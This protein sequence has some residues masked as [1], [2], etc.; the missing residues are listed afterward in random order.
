MQPD[1]SEPH[2]IQNRPQQPLS[3]ADRSCLWGLLG[4]FGCLVVLI[5]LL[6]IAAA[7]GVTVVTEAIAAV[8]EQLAPSTATPA[9]L[10]TATPT[11]TFIPTATPTLTPSPTPDYTRPITQSV[12]LLGQLVSVSWQLAEAQIGVS[13]RQGVLDACSFSNQH[14][15]EGTI[16]A[17]IDLTGFAASDVQYDPASDT[18]TIT[19]P[20]PQLTSCRV[21]DI[22]QYSGSVS[23]CGVN[24]DDARRLAQYIAVNGF[25]DDALERGILSRAQQQASFVIANFVRALTGSNVQVVF[26]SDQPALPDSCQP[27]I[28]D[29]WVY[30]AEANAWTRP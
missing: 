30:D 15:A 7:T 24:R 25:R 16:E 27:E 18:Y 12:Q 6:G 26:R 19:L 17:G 23:L 9:P 10:P 4:A 20:A 1:H 22:Q 11:G 13:V 29:G 3:S 21:D 8:R 2:P 28:P 14:V 5:A